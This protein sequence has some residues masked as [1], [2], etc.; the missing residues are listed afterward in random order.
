MPH[1]QMKSDVEDDISEG[2]GI[3]DYM[4][5]GWDESNYV[6]LDFKDDDF[7]GDGNYMET[8]EVSDSFQ[9]SWDA[10]KDVILE[11]I[12]LK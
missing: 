12:Y 11:G 7:N 9:P 8:H 10:I 1:S 6:T 5:N 4:G 2:E 3:D